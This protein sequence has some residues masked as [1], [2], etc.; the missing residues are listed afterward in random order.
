MLCS[1]GSFSMICQR[2]CTDLEKSLPSVEYGITIGRLV[3]ELDALGVLWR[4]VSWEWRRAL[5]ILQVMISK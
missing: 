3:L 5:E 4:I 2:S 1:F